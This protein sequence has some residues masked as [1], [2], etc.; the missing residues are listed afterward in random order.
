M[1]ALYVKDLEGTKTPLKA[2]F[3]GGRQELGY[4][5]GTENVPLIVGLGKASELAMHR[6][7][8]DQNHLRCVRDQFER[9]IME[10][11]GENVIIHG[12]RSQ[13]EK[14]ETG[15]LPN[16]SNV[17][18]MFPN[19]TSGKAILDRLGDQVMASVGA[20]CHSTGLCESRVLLA[21]HVSKEQ[22]IYAIRF[23]FGRLTTF[24]EIQ[25]LVALLKKLLLQEGE[26][27]H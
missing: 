25:R 15:R 16:T 21:S 5:S 17:S 9:M 22:A 2:V 1:G 4:R 24:E 23:S 18:L 3:H 19:Y 10:A 26:P 8:E 13:E 14:E 6:L 27:L 20:A 12:Q 11:F 7:I